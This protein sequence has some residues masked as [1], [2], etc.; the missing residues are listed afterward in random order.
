[1]Q[2]NFLGTKV[3]TLFYNDS[4]GSI[5]YIDSFLNAQ[6]DFYK[7]NQSTTNLT[8]SG[9]DVFITTNP[10]NE[11]IAKKLCS[12]ADAIGLGNHDIEGG[13]HLAHLI[14]KYALKGKMLASNLLF[15]RSCEM[16][17][18]VCPSTIIEKNGEKFGVIGV[19]PFEFRELCFSTSENDFFEVKPLNETLKIVKDEVKKLQQQGINKIFLLAHTGQSTDE[20]IDF[21]NEFASID[22]IDV[23]I[24]GH[25]H[26]E[27][28]RWAKSESGEPVKIVA[29][30]K[31]L[32]NDFRENLNM[33]GILELD[34]DDDGVL[35]KQNTKTTFKTLKE[36]QE[37]PD[38][39]PIVATIAEPLMKGNILLGH[40]EVGN[41]VADSNLWYVN[42]RTKTK[43]ADFAFVNAGTIRAN[44]NQREVSEKDI[45]EVVPFVSQK[46]IKTT[47][48][49]KQ[50]I[51]TLNWCAES[52]TFKK[53]TPGVMQV[54]N[55][56]YT[57]NPDA[58]VS[59]V[60]VLNDDGSVKYELDKLDD[61]FELTVVYDDFLATGVAGLSELV[62]DVEMDRN[63]E[64]YDVTR[65]GALKDYLI[66]AT[67]RDCKTPRI[68]NLI[69]Y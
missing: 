18:E 37:A 29:T 25:D 15:K 6:K 59:D 17:R 8:M 43:K 50:V 45:Q 63:I 27:V 56:T 47:L 42:S 2:I 22:G 53:V 65:Q 7:N 61:D 11:T 19:S 48:T 34:F 60:K 4:H 9:G 33:Y 35:I 24:G 58:T 55:M 67:I 39:T 49:K 1:M 54:A 44:L 10:N 16:E 36:V 40:S 23:I 68:T 20:G 32:N 38:T 66:N 5:A 12:K 69:S 46:L 57:I 28:D 13:E 41:I 31:A 51:E 26:L 64:I 30:G 21:Y 3:N 52:S 14:Q 62:K